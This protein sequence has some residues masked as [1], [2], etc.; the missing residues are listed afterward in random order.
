MSW[1]EGTFIYTLRP[2]SFM[3]EK[4]KEVIERYEM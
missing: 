3:K 4:D 2:N 1:K